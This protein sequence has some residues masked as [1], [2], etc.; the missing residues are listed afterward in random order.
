VAIY[1]LHVGIISRG[2]G[3][4]AVGAAAYRAADK[5]KSEYDYQKSN[6]LNALHIEVAKCYNTKKAA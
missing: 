1:H 3:R 2:A 4:S 6:S 5:L